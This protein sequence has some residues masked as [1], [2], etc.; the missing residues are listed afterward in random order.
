[1]A[2]GLAF[3]G[4]RPSTIE[5]ASLEISCSAQADREQGQDST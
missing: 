1:M 3:Q 2:K 5:S 4:I